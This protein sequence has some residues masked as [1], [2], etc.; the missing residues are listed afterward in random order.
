MSD[1]TKA[2]RRRIVAHIKIEADS[3]DDLETHLSQLAMQIDVEGQLP[4]TSI[5]GGYSS[6]HIITTS[7]DETIT[8]DSWAADLEAYLK[9][10]RDRISKA[11]RERISQE[12]G[13]S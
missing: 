13:G 7:E 8:H 2:P 10:E 3:W 11:E 9:A 1:E 5:S 4:P 12:G 6:G